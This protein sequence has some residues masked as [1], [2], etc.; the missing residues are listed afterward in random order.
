MSYVTDK[1]D[2]LFF[3]ELH[4][5]EFK[6]LKKNLSKKINA[7]IFNQDGF[8]LINDKIKENEKTLILI[9][10]SYEIKDD[11]EKV[12]NKLEELNN[13]YTN[14][15][16]L[17]WYPVLNI[18]KNDLFIENIRKIGS[19]RITRVE[20]PFKKYNDEIGMKG[21]GIIVFNGNNFLIKNIKECSIELY[22]LFKNEDCNIKPKIQRI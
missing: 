18:E 15:T 3:Y 21:C 1:E 20:L 11:F 9:D 22:K 17:V 6:I 7:K 5:N 14:T 8:N 12:I 16:A 10:P 13:F 4:K 19:N 2:K